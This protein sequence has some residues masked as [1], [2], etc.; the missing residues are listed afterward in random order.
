M[1][2]LNASGSPSGASNGST[3]TASAPPTPAANDATQVRSMF[4]QGSYLLIIGREVTA[5]WRCP[6]ASRSTSQSSSTRCPEPAR[7]A[8][9]GDGGELL[10]GRGVAELQQRRGLGRVD[11][12]GLQD[13]EVGDAHG[14][15]VAELLRVGG[16]EVVHGRA[17]DDDRQRACLACELG[18]PGHDLLHVLG[19]PAATDGRADRVRAEVGA[20]GRGDPPFCDH[21]GERLGGG[22]GVAVGLEHDR[23]QVEEHPVEGRREVLVGQPGRA[24]LQPQRGGAVLEVGDRRL[25]GGSRVRVRERRT[26]VP[27]RPPGGTACVRGCTARRRG[28]PAS[29]SPATRAAVPSGGTPIPSS[30]GRVSASQTAE[31]GSSAPSRP[32]LRSTAAAAFSQSLT[33]YCWPSARARCPSAGAFSSMGSP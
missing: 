6:R 22:N 21:G 25:R 27:A 1:R 2:R 15:R 16:A 8:E 7:G 23:S 19:D 33:S 20:L 30:V 10:V 28:H 11:P 29:G 24:D 4:T 26:H 14:E 9:L 17:V 18:D 12:G 31:S 5:C 3:V 32:A 13:P